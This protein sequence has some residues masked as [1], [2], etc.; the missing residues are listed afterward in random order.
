MSSPST[1][2]RLSILIP[3]YNRAPKL[4]RVLHNIDSELARSSLAG[5][6]DV[7][8]SDNAS[9]D[10]TPQVLASFRPASYRLSSFRQQTNLGLD[11]NTLFLYQRAASDYIWFFA[12]DDTLLPGA[13][14]KVL[15]ALDAHSPDVLLYSFRQPPD[16]PGRLFDFPGPVEVIDDP[17]RIVGLMTVHGKLSIHILR[18]IPLDAAEKKVLDPFLGSDVCYIP[19]SF[20]VLRGSARPRLCIIPD[21]LA[22]CDDD[23]R[24]V[25]FPPNAW[26]S[27]WK[28]CTHPF[29]LQ[30]A[31]HLLEE[32]RKDGYY[33][34]LYILFQVKAGLLQVDDIQSYDA[35]IKD[36]G[37]RPGLLARPRFFLKFL[38]LKFCSRIIPAVVS[39]ALAV[40]RFRGGEI[41]ER[42]RMM[43]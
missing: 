13:I 5:R 30:H 37:F 36:L 20:S 3:T 10:S 19:L 17:A 24:Q 33:N 11:A 32:K 42:Y 29:A 34:F 12:D 28:V 23:Y 2:P 6:V 41:A 1:S 14:D 8:V 22:V 21:V 40:I 27:F 26:V 15:R 18:R 25:R 16:Y 9:T 7:L 31:P 35:A 38:M 4:A 43:R 39:L